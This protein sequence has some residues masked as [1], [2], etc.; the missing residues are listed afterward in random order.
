MTLFQRGMNCHIKNNKEY[1]LLYT[2]LI[3]N[4]RNKGLLGDGEPPYSFHRIPDPT[5][6]E[7]VQ[8]IKQVEEPPGK[9]P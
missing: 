2:A 6:H 4:K 7:Q 8:R 3:Y 9:F 1:V 5:Q